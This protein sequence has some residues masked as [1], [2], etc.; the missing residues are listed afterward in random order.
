MKSSPFHLIE[1]LF[2]LDGNPLKMP[3]DTMRHLLP[4][5][6]TMTPEMLLMFGRQTH[7]S[8]TVGNKLVF[9]SLMIPSYRSLY[10]AP[11]GTQASVFSTDKLDGTI[12][13]SPV[14]EQFYTGPHYAN[15]IHYKE[16]KNNSKIYL[17]SAFRNADSIRGISADQVI[18]DEV[19]DI[20][21]DNIPVIRQ[22]M[23]H[24]M[25]HGETLHQYNNSIPLGLFNNT[26]YAGTPK[27]ME[28]TL[29]FQ[30]NLSNQTEFLIK[31]DH[32]GKTNYID[33][34]NIG[35]TQLICRVCGLPIWYHNGRW[36]ETN[37]RGK[38]PGFR[39]PQIV[40]PWINNPKRPES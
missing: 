39:L 36:V 34:K 21:R 24:S 27:T 8:T 17:R 22:C 37:P 30:W 20:I 1:N 18:F 4:I 29:T 11:T 14:I 15:Q 10:V 25:Q 40:L 2:Y 31:C 12:F 9:P 7:K 26:V 32:C 16:F 5:Y 35:A 13:G 6:N 23:G 19:Q 33:E 28:N 3:H 38:F